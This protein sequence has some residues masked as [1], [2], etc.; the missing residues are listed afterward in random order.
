[1][2]TIDDLT[3]QISSTAKDKANLVADALAVA[4]MNRHNLTPDK[5]ILL[6]REKDSAFEYLLQ[7]EMVDVMAGAKVDFDDPFANISNGPW[8]YHL[9]QKAVELHAALAQ[10]GVYGFEH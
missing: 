5:D 2:A 9:N 10:E 7:L 6:A 1:M 3:A 8:R 4:V